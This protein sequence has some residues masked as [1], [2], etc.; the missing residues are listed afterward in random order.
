MPKAQAVDVVAQALLGTAVLV[1]RE[2]ER[3][4]E[5][6][7]GRTLADLLDTACSPGGTTVAGLVAMERAGFSSAVIEAVRAVV[8][9]DRELA[10]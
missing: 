5:D 3:R 9:A 10:G 2:A 7:T 8:A 4:A 6:G 1:R